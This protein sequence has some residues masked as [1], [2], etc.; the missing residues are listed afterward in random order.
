M[1][2]LDRGVHAALALVST[3]CTQPMSNRQ[4]ANGTDSVET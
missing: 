2:G 4:T 3:I 1:Q